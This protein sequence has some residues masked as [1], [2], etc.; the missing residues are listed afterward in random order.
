VLDTGGARSLAGTVK[1]SMK[2]CSYCGQEN[3]DAAVACSGCG[4]PITEGGASPVSAQPSKVSCPKCGTVDNYRPALGLRSSFSLGTFLLGGI[5][6]VIFQ[7]AGRPK[8]VMCGHCETLFDIQTPGSRL[9]KAIFWL[10]I[11]PVILALGFAL[12]ALIRALL[13]HG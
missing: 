6:A 10:L 11:S 13:G 3:N 7:N 2:K 4:S 1:L 8:R 5:W 9:S 12:L